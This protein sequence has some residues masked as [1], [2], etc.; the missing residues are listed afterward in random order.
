MFDIQNITLSEMKHICCQH[1][2]QNRDCY[3]C[4]MYRFCA[5]DMLQRDPSAWRLSDE[6]YKKECEED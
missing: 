2:K 4:P 5:H 6:D 3:S 1:H